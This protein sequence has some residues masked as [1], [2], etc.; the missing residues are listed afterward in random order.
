MI[1]ATLFATAVLA[2]TWALAPA[3]QAHAHLHESTPA[4]GAHVAAA[5]TEVRLTFSEALTE[6]LSKATVE[7]PKG[8]AGAGPAKLDAKDHKTLVAP[9]KSPV[10]AG[11]YTVHWRAVSADSHTTQGTF[12]FTVGP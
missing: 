2:A 6:A 5:P 4:A 1:S 12:T 9:L 11:A 8:F 7:G 10:P 3:A